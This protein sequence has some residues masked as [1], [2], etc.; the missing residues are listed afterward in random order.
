MMADS[1]KK[2]VSMPSHAHELVGGYALKHR[3]TFS[4][5]VTE[6]CMIGLSM[7]ADEPIAPRVREIVE[8]E[9]GAPEGNRIRLD[10]APYARP[11][12]QHARWAHLARSRARISSASRFVSTLTPQHTPDH[13]RRSSTTLFI[14]SSRFEE[15]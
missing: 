11:T 14:T 1:V 2:S 4:A 13:A 15:L 12:M 5:A 7:D 6:L 9:G 8:S 10:A 3:L